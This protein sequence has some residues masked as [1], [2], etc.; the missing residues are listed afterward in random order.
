MPLVYGHSLTSS[1]A[2][3]LDGQVFI[4]NWSAEMAQAQV[5]GLPELLEEAG[6]CF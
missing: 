5:K 4:K 2:L 6:V 1:L 3:S